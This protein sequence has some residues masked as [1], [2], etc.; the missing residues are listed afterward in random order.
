MRD[1]LKA[2][3]QTA[4]EAE[5]ERVQPNLE[6]PEYLSE[7]ANEIGDTTRVSP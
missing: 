6:P 5:I 7:A 3:I 2:V 4:M 1:D